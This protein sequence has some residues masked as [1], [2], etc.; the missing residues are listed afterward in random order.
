MKKALEH[1]EI[2]THKSANL[3]LKHYAIEPSDQV[4]PFGGAK[5]VGNWKFVQTIACPSLKLNNIVIFCAIFS[6]AGRLKVAIKERERI[7]RVASL[8]QRL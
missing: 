4:G 6:T 3:K 5:N 8:Y 2:R 7:V 1:D